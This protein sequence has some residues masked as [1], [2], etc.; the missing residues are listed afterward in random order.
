VRLSLL[1]VRGSTP[2]PGN[3]FAGVGGNTSCVAIG[4]DDDAPSLVLD[5]GTG[6]RRLSGL[7]CGRPFRGSILLTHLH[8]DHV[9]GLPFFAAGD[10]DDA[11]VRLVMPNQGD[12][13]DV[14]SRAMSP[15]HF[16]IGPEGLRGKWRFDALSEGR[17]RIEGFDIL[18]LEIAHK[19]GLTFGYRVEDERSS[20]AYLPDHALVSRSGTESSDERLST[21]ALE[22]ATGVD[23]LIHDA[24][25]VEKERGTAVAYG[26]ATIEAAWAFAERAGAARLILFHHGPDRNDHQL[27]STVSALA[28]ERCK[29]SPVVAE[30]GYETQVLDPTEHRTVS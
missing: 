3:E 29:D 23:I 14:L 22:L 11:E 7:L 10:R 27:M 30:V 15:P 1:G 25:F 20:V 26:H 24:Q 16:P 17:H 8:W 2:A 9:Q 19:G 4:H 21:N 6:L 5:A 12:P 13:V 28:Q 18:A